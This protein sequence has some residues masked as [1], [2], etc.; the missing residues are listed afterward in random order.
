MQGAGR[1]RKG[2]TNSAAQPKAERL[3]HTSG[4]TGMNPHSKMMGLESQVHNG[5]SKNHA[6]FANV[7]SVHCELPHSFY[8]PVWDSRP[9][10]VLSVL[11]RFPYPC[12]IGL[13]KQLHRYIPNS[14]LAPALLLG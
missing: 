4:V 11:M 9:S 14:A 3:D 5:C 12:A 1:I 13:W 8:G 2:G 6:F 7:G 10:E